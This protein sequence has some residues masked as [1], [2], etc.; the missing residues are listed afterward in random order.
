M[1]EFSQPLARAMCF[2]MAAGLILLFASHGFLPMLGLCLAVCGVAC[3]IGHANR[4]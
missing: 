4:S 2:A 3:G 1:S